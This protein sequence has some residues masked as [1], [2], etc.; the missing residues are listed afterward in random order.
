MKS[1][2]RKKLREEQKQWLLDEKYEFHNNPQRMF[3]NMIEE[4]ECE[5]EA[6]KMR[7]GIYCDTC[8]LFLR[9][10]QYTLD[11]FK[12][13]AEGRSSFHPTKFVK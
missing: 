13:E 2:E 7:V 6:T 11:L 1:E 5:C 8:K 3:L 10:W 9:L 4:V 12:D